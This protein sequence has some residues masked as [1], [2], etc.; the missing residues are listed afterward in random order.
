MID[1]SH[2][3]PIARQAKALNVS[4]GS[5]YYLPRPGRPPT[6][7]HAA[8]GRIPPRLPVRGQPDV[9][10]SPERDGV[11]I[12]RRHV[13]TLMNRMGIEAMYRKPNTNKPPPGHKI[14]PYL[15]RK[16]GGPARPGLGRWTSRTS[17]WRAASSTAAVVDGSAGGFWPSGVDHREVVLH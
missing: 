12:G 10:G 8:D 13:A 17:R 4:R 2:E 6:G 14:Y 15:L 9:A 3:L 11:E 1:R 7:R 16:I 5:V